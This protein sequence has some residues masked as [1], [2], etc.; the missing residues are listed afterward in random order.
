[1]PSF[2]ARRKTFGLAG[3][4]A[5]AVSTTVAGTALATHTTH[6][7]CKPAIFTTADVSAATGYAV[8][9]LVTVPHPPS[10]IPP[11]ANAARIAGKTYECDWELVH[12]GEGGFGEGRVSVFVFASPDDANRWFTAYAAAET[13]PCKQISFATTTACRQVSR[14][15]NGVFPQLQAVQGQFVVWVHMAQRKFNLRPLEALA[16]KVLARA[17]QLPQP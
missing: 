1:M 17:P 16:T 2:V 12:W 5:A 4:I 13:P 8:T 10:G 15:P 14:L 11:V 6:A 7:P 9:N 3:L